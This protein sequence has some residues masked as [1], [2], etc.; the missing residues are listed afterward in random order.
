M[1][2]FTVIVLCAISY[3]TVCVRT[4]Y[5]S[6][7]LRRFPTFAAYAEAGGPALS[8]LSG[9]VELAILSGTELLGHHSL[10]QSVRL[11]G[12][13]T[14]LP[15]SWFYAPFMI[16]M[17][18]FDTL[19]H[20]EVGAGVSVFLYDISGFDPN[21]G[22]RDDLGRNPLFATTIGY[23]FEPPDGGFMLR[24]GYTPFFSFASEQWEFFFGISAGYSF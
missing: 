23:R 1:R 22:I 8:Y 5:A 2:L 16:K 15:M 18:F 10:I 21:D 13:V 4:M 6:D 14:V 12:G 9:H 20:F 11:S 19:H 7:P 24:I 17:L 3:P